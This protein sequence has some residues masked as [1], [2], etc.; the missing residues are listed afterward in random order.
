MKLLFVQHDKKFIDF[1]IPKLIPLGVELY[2]AETKQEVYDWLKNRD[3]NSL[4]FNITQETIHWLDFISELKDSDKDEKLKIAVYLPKDNH[5]CLRKLYKYGITALIYRSSIQDHVT[6]Q[7][8]SIIRYLEHEGERRGHVRVE[9]EDNEDFRI[10]FNFKGTFI[11]VP[12]F[13]IST[14]A[15]S[16]KP[17]DNTLFEITEKKEIITGIKLIIH[18]KTIEF[19]A[20][21]AR[22]NHMVALMFVNLKQDFLNVVCNFIFD[23][24]NHNS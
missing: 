12:V 5:K 6:T 1:M 4:F 20:I 17:T 23:K 19:E 14:V 21:I 24:L 18:D 16:F 9:V 13:A 3:N 8:L 10:E 7:M 22:S 11:N 15:L 2:K